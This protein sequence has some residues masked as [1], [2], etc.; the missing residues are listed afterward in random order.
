MSAKPIDPNAGLEKELAELK[1]RC[2][3]LQ[4]KNAKLLKD[5]RHW[6]RLAE[7]REMELARLKFSLG[8]KG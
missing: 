6:R 1:N 8:E 7:M 4:K 3:R 5:A 2:I